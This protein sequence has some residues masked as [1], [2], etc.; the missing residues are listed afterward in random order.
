MYIFF[1]SFKH[2]SLQYTVKQRLRKK[3][4]SK[5]K[6]E[7]W[8]FE[9]K[10]KTFLKPCS[11][12]Q[13][14]FLYL[15]WWVRERKIFKNCSPNTHS[16][17]L[18]KPSPPPPPKNGVRFFFHQ[19]CDC[20]KFTSLGSLGPAGARHPV[21][22][23]LPDCQHTLA[24]VGVE[25]LHVMVLSSSKTASSCRWATGW[26]HWRASVGRGLLA[27]IRETLSKTTQV[28]SIP[29][30]EREKGSRVSFLLFTHANR[31][32]EVQIQNLMLFPSPPHAVP[33]TQ[34]PRSNFRYTA[35][36]GS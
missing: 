11:L 18:Q 16:F 20:H 8:S 17:C 5:K 31:A 1:F 2:K 14:H 7:T 10:L 32:A 3:I 25:S 27:G 30:G 22:A 35:A 28:L 9:L 12:N 6:K 34:T 23:E 13:W 24:P 33:G 26:L 15:C 29:W 4:I 21:W 19:V 36:F